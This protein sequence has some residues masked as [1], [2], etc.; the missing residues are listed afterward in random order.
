M[1]TAFSLSEAPRRCSFIVTAPY[2]KQQVLALLA[3]TMTQQ[4]QVRHTYDSVRHVS[5][6]SSRYRWGRQDDFRS[7]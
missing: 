5:C 1:R 7:Y 3:V 6:P 4:L 2:P